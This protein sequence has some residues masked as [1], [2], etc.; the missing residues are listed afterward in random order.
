VASW[1][2][3]LESTSQGYRRRAAKLWL[4]SRLSVL[5]CLRVSTPKVEIP[6]DEIREEP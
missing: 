1:D 2:C 5:H 4:K 6:V 3:K